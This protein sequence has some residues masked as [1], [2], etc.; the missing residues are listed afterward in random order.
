MP[1]ERTVYRI[2]ERIGA[3][4]DLVLYRPQYQKDGIKKRPSLLRKAVLTKAAP[5]KETRL[6][7]KEH[8]MNIEWLLAVGFYIAAPLTA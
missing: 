6:R 2:M 8:N 3:A 7:R 1:G 5:Q 4:H